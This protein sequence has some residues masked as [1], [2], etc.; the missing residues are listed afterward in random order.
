MP[1][2]NAEKIPSITLDA[3]DE[4]APTALRMLAKAMYRYGKG[5]VLKAN[6]L[7]MLAEEMEDWYKKNG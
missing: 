6:A 2:E 4:Y 1:H 3:R 5:D 7:I